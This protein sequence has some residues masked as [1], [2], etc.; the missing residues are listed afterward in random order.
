VTLE[1]PSHLVPAQHK[2]YAIAALVIGVLSFVIVAIVH[3]NVAA[4][5]DWKLSVPGFVLALAASAMSLV[6]REPQ[7]YWLWALGVGLAAAGIVLG[8][9]LL[10]AI[11][12]G[13][14]AIIILILHAVM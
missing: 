7:G 2:P 5:P 4:L 6:R 10:L 1:K 13:A 3:P 9:F 8:W 12:I 14:T 11:V